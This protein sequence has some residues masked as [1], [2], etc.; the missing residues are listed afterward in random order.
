MQRKLV[1]RLQALAIIVGLI[2]Y[3][4]VTLFLIQRCR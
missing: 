3:V 2:A 4:V 1:E